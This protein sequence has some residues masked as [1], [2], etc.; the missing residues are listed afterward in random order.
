MKILK[1][2]GERKWMPSLKKIKI[3]GSLE[4]NDNLTQKGQP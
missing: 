2:D 4:Q 1:K 3:K